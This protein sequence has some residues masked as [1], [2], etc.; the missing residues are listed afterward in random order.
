MRDLGG[1]RG[2][3]EELL[4]TPPDPPASKVHILFKSLQASALLRPRFQETPSPKPSSPCPNSFPAQQIKVTASKQRLPSHPQQNS[5]PL[6]TPEASAQR[7]PCLPLPQPPHLPA[8]PTGDLYRPG[9]PS[10]CLPSV[11]VRA[12]SLGTHLLMGW[13]QGHCQGR[14]PGVGATQQA[15][16]SRWPVS[17]NQLP[18]RLGRDAAQWPSQRRSLHYQDIKMERETAPPR[19]F[20]FIQ[21]V[22]K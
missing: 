20:F 16:L 10:L 11:G 17:K 14:L 8:W 12:G 4:N 5:H 2:K 9:A 19:F 21:S 18:G 7:R 15:T 22:L 3:E 13:A 1:S 6:R